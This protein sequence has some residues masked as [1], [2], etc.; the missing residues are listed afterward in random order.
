MED[1]IKQ[2]KLYYFESCPPSAL[3]E[4][5]SN[6]R[7]KLYSPQKGWVADYRRLRFIAVKL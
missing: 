1:W 4:V 3:S 7:P 5:V 2:F 6:L